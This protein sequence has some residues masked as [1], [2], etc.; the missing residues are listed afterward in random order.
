MKILIHANGPTAPTGYGVQ[1]ALLA[2]RLA[3]AGHQVAVSCTYGQQGQVSTWTSPRGHKIRLYPA[4]M[5][6]TGNDI[7]HGHANHWFEGDSRGG[8][9]I[10]LIDV[11]ALKN[12]A[13]SEYNVAAWTPVDHYPLP[14]DVWGFFKRTGAVP[15]AMSQFGH[16]QMRRFGLEAA[17]IPLAVDTSVFKPTY[18]VNIRPDV[19]LRP[20]DTDPQGTRVSGR[21]LLHLP[22]DA[23]VVG[24]VGM[25]KGWIRDRKGFNE[26]FRAFAAFQRR[27]SNAVLHVHSEAHGLAD[28][29][30]LLTLA[31]A[32]GIP[33]SALSF[34]DQ[35]AYRVGFP[36][37]MMAATYTA[38]D[39]LLAPSHGEGFCVPLIE[40]QACGT[41]V[42]CSDFS[43]QSE[44][45]GPGWLVEG[46]EEWDESQKS[47]FLVPSIADIV[48]KLEAAYKAL[49]E[50]PLGIEEECVRFAQAYDAD[51]IFAEHWVPFLETLTP[52]EPQ[53]D[54]PVMDRVAVVVPVMNRPHNVTTVVESF[55]LYSPPES[56]LYFVTDA[57]D[58]AER[59]A[60]A[61]EIGMLPPADADRVVMLTTD[62][63][64]T[65]AQKANYAYQHTD[66][67]WL[68]ICGDDVRFTSGWID[69]ARKLSDRWDVIGTN[70]SEPGRVR[71]LDVAAGRHA[72][73]FFVRR[74]YV[75]DT[76][77]CLEGEGVMMPECYNHW[78][79]DIEVVGLAKARN[80]FAPCLDS[81]VV[82]LHPGYDGDEDR[83]RDDPTYMRAVEWAE[84]DRV[85]YAKRLPL[86]DMARA[87]AR[88]ARV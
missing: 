11:W 83:R 55:L 45:V 27:H 33:E 54:R 78:F 69:E 49:S 76:G 44:L 43:S 16:E 7:I 8:W 88:G 9:I 24:M 70:D 39:V 56:S 20:E 1:C 66:E 52:P 81:R 37:S 71:N 4:G 26:A 23:F 84:H 6:A 5:D 17:Y 68:F 53:P 18:S 35:Y 73:H 51:R 10:P 41:P 42:V 75:E 79:V 77:S 32:A 30:D 87:E 3:E 12:P 13:L 48:D 28:G 34:V 72:D 47:S 38:F 50:D 74:S 29:I 25:N 57:D 46:Q 85:T 64:H 63:G 59:E 61:T 82:H 58:E 15:I 60:I 40:A 31:K 21:E 65:Y 22:L 14:P 2:D 67:D 36:P 62:R 80:R 86:I 19:T